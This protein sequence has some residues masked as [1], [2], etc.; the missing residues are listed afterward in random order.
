MTPTPMPNGWARDCRQKRNGRKRLAALMAECG[1]GATVTCRA[2]RISTAKRMDMNL[3][4]PSDLSDRERAHMAY[5]IWPAM[6]GNGL[7]V[8]SSRIRAVRIKI[9][10]ITRT[11][12]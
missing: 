5:K 9:N 1:P 3:Q 7:P 12:A 11:F 8:N 2:L 10:D 4:R 6:Y